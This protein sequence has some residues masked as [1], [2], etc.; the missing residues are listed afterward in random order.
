MTCSYCIVTGKN[1]LSTMLTKSFQ[2]LPS[3]QALHVDS[4]CSTN[5][6][7]R[8]NACSLKPAVHSMRIK[9][10]V[11][12]NGWFNLD[13]LQPFD[14]ISYSVGVH[15]KSNMSQHVKSNVSPHVKSNVSPHV[16]SNMSPRIKSNMSQHV[17]STC[18][19]M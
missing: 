4:R 9:L 10:F 2:T 18:P 17:K 8:T 11:S 6:G 13:W 3:T 5:P 16:K 15:V 1:Y 12:I 7:L 19:N 14:H